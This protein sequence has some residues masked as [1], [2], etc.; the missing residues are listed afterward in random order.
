[1]SIGLT[2]ISCLGEVFVLQPVSFPRVSHCSLVV[3]QTRS[4]ASVGTAPDLTQLLS[5]PS[6]S[7]AN[8]QIGESIWTLTQGS[9]A[10]PAS[11]TPTHHSTF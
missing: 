8:I 11:F 7:E 10:F 4:Q 5:L 6:P 1:M 9:P 2:D 3:H